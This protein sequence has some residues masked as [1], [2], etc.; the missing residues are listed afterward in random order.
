MQG[1]DALV[2][3]PQ[4]FLKLLVLHVAE[5]LSLDLILLPA[6]V[7]GFTDLVTLACVKQAHQCFGPDVRLKVV[8]GVILLL[9]QS[10]ELLM[11]N[12]DV[13]HW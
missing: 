2:L 3:S 13:D 8:D 9:F 7:T 1:L 6:E 5:D 4:V 11:L 10:V 12:N